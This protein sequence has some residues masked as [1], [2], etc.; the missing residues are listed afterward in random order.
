MR[1]QMKCLRYS[2]GPIIRISFVGTFRLL[3]FRRIHI[4]KKLHFVTAVGV[5]LVVFVVA[6]NPL[7]SDL[8]LWNAFATLYP[9]N[10]DL[11]EKK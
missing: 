5:G 4:I 1:L 11:P 2:D 9:P 10:C 6:R 7:I 8:C 3:R